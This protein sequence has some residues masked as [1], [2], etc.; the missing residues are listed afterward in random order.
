MATD[1][2]AAMERR[3]AIGRRLREW[4]V[5]RELSQ[6]QVARA[7]GITQAS[8]SN[9]ETGKRD[10]PLSTLFGVAAALNV[11]LG[12]LLDVPD[13][14]VVRDSRVGRAVERLVQRPEL[15]DALT[16]PTMTEA[17]S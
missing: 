11:D 2:T 3:R 6:A 7:G 9:Y 17:A 14:V 16:R 8:L 13:V 12:D 5:K 1:S 15:A 4:R 10:L